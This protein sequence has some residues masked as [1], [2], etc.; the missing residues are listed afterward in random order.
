MASIFSGFCYLGLRDYLLDAYAFN[1][2]LPSY[3]LRIP[4]KRSN[5][6]ENTGTQSLDH[7]NSD[8]I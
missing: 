1:P 7:K 2:P 3:T 6:K 5:F 8:I 4:K